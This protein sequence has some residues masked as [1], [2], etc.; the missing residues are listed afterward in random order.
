MSNKYASLDCNMASILIVEDDLTFSKLV[1]SYLKRHGHTPY[2]VYDVKGA[3]SELI[4]THF[5]LLLLDYRLPDGTGMDVLKYK[6]EHSLPTPVVIMT[7]FHDIRTTVKAIRSGAYDYITKPVNPEE[8]LMVIDQAMQKPDIV[9]SPVQ[10]KTDFVEGDSQ[11]SL[12]IHKHI[13]LVAPTD[14]SVIIQ[15]DSGT[16]KEQVARNIHRL[17]KRATAPFIAIDCGALSNDLAGSELFGHVK[18]A[19]TGALQDKKGQFDLASGGTLFLDEVGNLSYEI[20]VKL[21][22]ALQEREI[23]PL[24]S[25][26]NIKVNVR[27]I[28]ATN[29]DLLNSVRNSN[30]REDLYHRLNEFK[31]L[32]PSLQQRKEDLHLFIS[33]FISQANKELGKNVKGLSTEVKN[34]FYKYDW[35]GNLRE[36]RNII[37]RAVLLTHDNEIQMAALPQE[38]ILALENSDNSDTHDLKAIQADNEKD[39][40]LKTLQEVKYNKTKAAKL[41]N[42]D[43]KTLYYKMAKYNIDG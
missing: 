40:I 17:S 35:P 31:I 21:L 36:L 11:L 26:K 39:M 14:M 7:S 20:Q 27:I 12:Q 19:F 15:G 41:L 25:G 13:Q 23:Q 3:L 32:L 28:T 6:H 24:G 4:K 33:H 34:V 5:D 1:E 29:D 9:A 18:G 10:P 37:K 42:I 22:R 16:G 2:C 8:L 38:M 43:R 30:F